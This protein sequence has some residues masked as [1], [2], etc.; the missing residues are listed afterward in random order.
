[1]VN[2]YLNG[3]RRGKRKKYTHLSLWPGVKPQQIWQKRLPKH[4]KHKSVEKKKM[5]KHEKNSIIDL[6]N[7]QKL[8]FWLTNFMQYNLNNE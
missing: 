5:Q 8:L 1:M 3:Q 4:H 7:V 6:L 2:R